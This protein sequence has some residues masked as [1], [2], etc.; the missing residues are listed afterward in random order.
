VEAEILKVRKRYDME[1]LFMTHKIV[2]INCPSYL[3]D[4]VTLASDT[5]VR[6]TK[7]HTNSNVRTP[8]VGVDAAENSFVVQNSGLWNDLPEKLCSN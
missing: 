6:T 5:S 4:F 7:E 2:H 3:T 1:I 8:R